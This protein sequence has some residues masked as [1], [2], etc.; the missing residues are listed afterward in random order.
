MLYERPDDYAAQRATR[1]SS[2]KAADVHLA[3]KGILPGAMTWVIV[4][5][6]SKIEKGIR[7]LKLGDVKVIDADGKVLR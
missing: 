2:L 5:D 3:A 6:L 4:G 1:I 7:D